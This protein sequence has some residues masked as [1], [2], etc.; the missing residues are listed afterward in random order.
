MS[1]RHPAR[2][3]A[4]LGAS[5]SGKSAAIRQHLHV[6]RPRRLLVWD[7]L[8]EYADH[9]DVCRSLR[10]TLERVRTRGGR[11][12]SRLAVIFQPPPERRA[13]P[14]AFST[15]CRLALA[16]GECTL[17]VEELALV[18][19]PHRAP[20]GWSAACLTG[21]HRGLEIIAAS[22]RPASV[23]KDFFSNATRVRTGRLNYA[24]DVRTVA[25]VLDVSPDEIRAL[26]PLE[27]IE[28][29]MHSGEIRRGRMTFSPGGARPRRRRRA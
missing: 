6:T 17:V 9:G 24:E 8:G 16:V 12:R 18:T 14:Q 15:F 27:W 3:V 28:R 19:Q 2:I 4:V 26:R 25:Q 22:Q 29:D 7:P 10:E 1:A 13:W 20:E 5:G 11:V 21:R 23:D